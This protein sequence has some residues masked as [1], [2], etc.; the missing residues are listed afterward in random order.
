MFAKLY[1]NIVDSTL[2]D[3][4]VNVRYVFMMMLAV[5]DPDGYVSSTPK[6]TAAKFNMEQEEFDRAIEV[7]MAPDPSSNFPDHE[8]RRLIP[9]DRGRGWLITTYKHYSQI[10]NEEHKRQYMREYMRNYRA[11]VKASKDSKEFTDYGAITSLTL[12]EGDVEAE[13]DQ[14]E[15]RERL[16]EDKAKT[17]NVSES[18]HSQEIGW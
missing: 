3:Q 7:L 13:V 16:E 5:A 6:A 15:T 18:A 17:S 4:P 2:M 14:N 11:R 12:L 10:R 9:S 8:G 1:S